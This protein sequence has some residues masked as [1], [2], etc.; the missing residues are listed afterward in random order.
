MYKSESAKSGDNGVS[1]VGSGNKVINISFEDKTKKTLSRSVLFDICKVI[2]ELDIEYEEEYSIQGNSDWIDKF[3]YNEVKAFID[4]FD[5]YSDGYNEV[6]KVLQGYLKKHL[7]VKKI[8]A[9]YLEVE[10]LR[11]KENLN[12]DHVL[13]QVFERLKEEV[14]YSALVIENELLDEEV[15]Q[16]IYLSMFYTFTKCKLLKPIPEVE[17]WDD[18]NR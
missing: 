3:E 11:E 10:E 2:A 5:N 7:M 15:D 16:A 9:V 8:R 1:I 18:D 12:G 4:V 14:C 13:K 17:V 6:S